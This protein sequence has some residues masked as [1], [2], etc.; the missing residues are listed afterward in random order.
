[1][2][3]RTIRYYIQ[4]AVRSIIYNR[5][6]SIASIFAVSSSIFI[7][8]IF[9]I[10]GANV[11]YFMGQ[12]EAQ[13]GMAVR[14]ENDLSQQ[15]QDL[16]H[17]RILGLHHVSSVTF[18]SRDDALQSMANTLGEDAVAGLEIINPLR[19]SLLVEL[20]DLAFHDE[21][22][23]AIWNLRAYGVAE[24]HSEAEFARTL[25]TISTIVSLISLVLVLIL[26]GI[27]MIIITN[28][29]R[30]TVNARKTEINIMKYVGAT[31]W[32]IRWPFVLEGMIIGLLGGFFPA[33]I[34]W[35]GY[36]RIIAAINDIPHLSFI[37]FIPPEYVMN[38]VFIFALVLG[39]VIGLI[40]SITSV[41]RHLKV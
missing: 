4:E 28:T 5:F 19:D 37:D 31:D 17:S 33:L 9:Y 39:V 7:V 32:F 14:L 15:E 41:K 30:I 12:M 34:C 8:S 29:I 38:Y 22:E 21:T 36:G 23:R 13:M 40:G 25:S 10:I 35:F 20:T 3:L 2:K 26:A 18:I 24:I 27:S 11:E 6:M 1:M 16:L